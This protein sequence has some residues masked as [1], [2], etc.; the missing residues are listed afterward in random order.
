MSEDAWDMNSG[1]NAVYGEGSST[2]FDSSLDGDACDEAWSLNEYGRLYNWDAV[3]DTRGLCPNG[4]H[5]PT[6][7]EWIM[8]EMALGMSEIE[9]NDTGIRGTDEGT[10]MKTSYGWLNGEN[11][12][13]SSGFSGLPGGLRACYGWFEDAGLLGAWWCSDEVMTRWLTAGTGVV[14]QD[15]VGGVGLS[16]RCISDELTCTLDLDSDGICDD[17][18]D[19][20]GQLDDCG[21]CNGPGAVYDCGCEECGQFVECGDPVSYQGYDYTTVLIGEQ[22]WFAENLRAENYRNGDVIPAG[23][24]NIEWGNTTIGAVAVYGES[25]DCNNYSP[26]IDACDP[27]QSLNEY[28]RLYNWYAVEDARGI[29]PSGWHVPTDGEWMS[30]EMALGMS[31]GMAN[32]TGWRGPSQGTQMKTDYGWFEGGNG[33]N[34]SGFS[35]LPGDQ[36]QPNG[37]FYNSGLNGLWWS[38]SPNGSDAWYRYLSNS[39]MGVY[40]AHTMPN[41]GYSIRCIKD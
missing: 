35:G 13:N 37:F 19:C 16:V 9:A 29:C 5:V 18:D 38:S 26:D 36:R 6:D 14:R 25:S 8:M 4:W 7:G 2:C 11:G 12:S 23:L 30:M 10:Q 17:V 1:A 31:E 28:G 32:L 40:R 22:C 15:T 34:S 41:F 24:V 33:S 21:V 39:H 20:V 3:D 27:T